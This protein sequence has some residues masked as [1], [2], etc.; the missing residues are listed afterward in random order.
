MGGEG[1]TL[2]QIA[3]AVMLEV[4]VPWRLGG[5]SQ[6]ASG[7]TRETKSLRAPKGYT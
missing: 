7:K 4:A 5:G 6:K 3:V 1:G 2:P